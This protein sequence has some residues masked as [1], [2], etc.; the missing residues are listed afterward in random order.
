MS[1]E[2]G[3]IVKSINWTLLMAGV[4]N[5]GILLY[6]LKRLLFK[7]ALEFLDRRREQIA[8]RIS[9]ARASEEEAKQLVVA[10][11][12]ELQQARG[13]A[14]EILDAARRDAE[15]IIAQAR[16]AAKSD[17]DKILSD[18]KHRLEQERDNMIHE[19]REA[20]ADI[21]ILGAERV[22]DRE[23]R[24]D[25]HRRLLDQL[26]EEINEETLRIPS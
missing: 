23:I 1:V 20:Y 21:A 3:K 16:N 4:I 10:R 22:L 26:L 15:S 8:A 5:F 18:G 9:A 13:R 6:I 14:E 11:E 24:I 7:P 17:A 25:D 19:L 12:A 2:W